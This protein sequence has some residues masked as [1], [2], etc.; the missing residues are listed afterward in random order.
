MCATWAGCC[1]GRALPCRSADVERLAVRYGDFSGLVRDL[2]AHGLT[3]VLSER[4]R[5]PLAPRHAGG[6]AG[7]LCAS[8]M[9]EDGKLLAHVRDALS[10][11]LGAA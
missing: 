2:R 11:R 3:N 6:A 5:K 4:S 10:D 8:I 7:A 1:S 9:R